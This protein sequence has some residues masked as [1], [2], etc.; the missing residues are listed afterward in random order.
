MEK[1][2]LKVSL[3]SQKGPVNI[4]SYYSGHGSSLNG[5]LHISAPTV[6]TQDDYVSQREDLPEVLPIS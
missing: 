3:Y 2:R 4:F 6:F 5:K 1:V